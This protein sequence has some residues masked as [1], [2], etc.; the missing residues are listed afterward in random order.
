MSLTEELQ[1]QSGDICSIVGA[2]GKTSLLYALAEESRLGRTLSTTTTMMRH[3]RIGKHPFRSIQ[4]MP[5]TDW[6][7]LEVSAPCLIASSLV[8]GVKEKIRG[9]LPGY[10]DQWQGKRWPLTLIEADGASERA[11]KMPAD[12]EPQI[13]LKTSVT[14][15]LIGLDILG[16]KA[17]SQTIHRFPLVRER[18]DLD[19][20]EP[21]STDHLIRVISHPEGLFKGTPT[22]SRRILVLN[23]SDCLKDDPVLLSRVID[24]CSSVQ[25]R[26]PSINIDTVL[27]T[28]LSDYSNPYIEKH[29]E[30]RSCH[31]PL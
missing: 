15:G 23:K 8:S 29:S 20:G 4:I 31:V 1:L 12:H 13:A 10:L 22:G 3:P 25:R 26:N 18:I 16:Q 17:S 27:I 28:R 30:Y 14:I 7:S 11:L 6:P 9:F 21:V 19:E 2:G 24:L 5:H